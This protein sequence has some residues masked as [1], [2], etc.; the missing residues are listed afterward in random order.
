LASTAIE[1]SLNSDGIA[2][3]T[4]AY[5]GR[6]NETEQVIFGIDGNRTVTKEGYAKVTYE[7]DNLGREIRATYL[8]AD[9]RQIVMELAVVHVSHGS[10][11]EKVGIK[12][13]DRVISYDGRMLTSVKQLTEAVSD[14]KGPPV[15]FVLVRRESQNMTFEVRPGF[16]RIIGRMMRADAA[17]GVRT[18][19]APGP[20][21]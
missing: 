5:D 1:R 21:P 15:R 7:Y 12:V 9:D 8:D 20:P 11:A 16:L 18:G 4:H 3:I 14:L 17:E 13:G 19:G 2:K 10:E 6:G